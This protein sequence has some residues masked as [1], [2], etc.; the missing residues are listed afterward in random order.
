VRM[1]V[2]IFWGWSAAN[3]GAARSSMGSDERQFGLLV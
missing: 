3:W 2:L 1:T